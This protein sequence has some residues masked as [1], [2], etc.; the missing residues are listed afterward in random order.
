MRW[1]VSALALMAAGAMAAPVQ[2]QQV[3]PGS[4][5]CPITNGVATC[6]GDLSDGIRYFGP[7]PPITELRVE[8]LLG[9]VAVPVHPE[10]TVLRDEGDDTSHVGGTQHPVGV[11]APGEDPVRGQVHL[12]RC[13]EV[14]E[15]L[16]EQ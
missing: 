3:S 2:A 6:T 11:V 1:G 10:S 9:R 14:D 12:L 4:A 7:N 15:A 13:R 5:R 8:D 16:V